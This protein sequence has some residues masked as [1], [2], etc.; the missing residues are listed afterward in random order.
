MP[1]NYL[2]EVNLVNIRIL[3]PK[4]QR[5]G[6]VTSLKNCFS[7][8]NAS[9]FKIRK[10]HCEHEHKH[11]QLQNIHTAYYKPDILLYLKKGQGTFPV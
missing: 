8:A 6:H 1:I 3:L 10:L 9:S 7:H 5:S 2:Y 4:D 11:L